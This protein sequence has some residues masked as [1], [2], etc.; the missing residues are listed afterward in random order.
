MP[1]ITEPGEAEEDTGQL[2]EE[3]A[4]A[5]RELEGP[6]EGGEEAA[7][8]SREQVVADT[9]RAAAAEVHVAM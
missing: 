4:R 5:S 6:E 1:F 9:G 7:A 3:A 8:A 2:S